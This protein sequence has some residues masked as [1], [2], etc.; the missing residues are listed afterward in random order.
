MG[1]WIDDGVFFQQDDAAERLARGLVSA[2]HHVVTHHEC[3]PTRPLGV[4]FSGGVDST[5]LLAVARRMN[6][7]VVAA[8]AGW[9]GT[10]S[11]LTRVRAI[12]LTSCFVQLLQVRTR[13]RWT[14]PRLEPPHTNWAPRSCSRRSAIYTRSS[15]RC[16]SCTAWC[17]AW[18]WSKR[19]WRCPCISRRGRFHEIIAPPRWRAVAARRS[20]VGTRGTARGPVTRRTSGSAA[21]DRCTTG[22][23]RG[24]P[25]RRRCMA[26]RRIS[27]F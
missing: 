26:C 19:V 25:R 24:T 14:Y 7:P 8:T 1:N 11:I 2:V 5:A 18:T 13:S 22:T 10:K 9:I 4:L 27:R 3:S 15:T 20:C 6:V 16:V 21:C 23:C 12:R 17:T